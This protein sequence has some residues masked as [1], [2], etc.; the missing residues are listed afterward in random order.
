MIPAVCDQTLGVECVDC[1]EIVAVCWMDE[2]IP[3]SLWNRAALTLSGAVPCAQNR[4]NACALC[5]REFDQT[6]VFS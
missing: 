5:E 2:H 6:L 4:D 3:E 1:G